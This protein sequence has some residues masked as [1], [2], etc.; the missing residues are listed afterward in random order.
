MTDEPVAAE[1]AAPSPIAETP[2]PAEKIEAKVETK[3]EPTTP[4][5]RDAA[6]TDELSAV[7]DKEQTNGT[8]RGDGGRFKSNKPAETKLADQP[9]AEVSEPATPAIE[10]PQSWSA[11][12]RAQWAKLPPEAQKYIAQRESDAHKAITSQGEKVKAFEPFDQISSRYKP[13]FD[14]HGVKPHEAFETLLRAHSKLEQDP[15][16][17]LVQVGLSYGIDLRPL[18]NGN[19]VHQ[20]DPR[21]QAL[22]QTVFQLTQQ[23]HQREQQAQAAEQ[24]QANTQIAEFAKDKPYFEE[25]RSFM[26]QL[27]ALEQA[28]TLQQAYDMA[29]HANPVIRERILSDQRKAAETKRAEEAKAKADEARKSGRVNVRSGTAQPSPRSMD[30]DIEALA[31]RLYG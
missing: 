12:A 26:G 4:E 10:A 27:I 23:H 7:W 13:V 22:E 24:A 20:P 25:V 3:P 17:G 29:T 2:A 28:T 14:R 6:L 31:A 30:E 8:D 9:Q 16:S 5:A 15:I 21:V 1:A 11:E 19:T 18:L